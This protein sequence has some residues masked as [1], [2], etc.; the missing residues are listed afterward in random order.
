MNIAILVNYTAN[1]NQGEKKWLSI[2][3]DILQMLPVTT[4]VITYKPPFNIEE[5]VLKLV[6]EQQI[7]YIIS[8]GGDGS[9]NYILNSIINIFGELTKKIHL[10]A[11]GLGSS[12]DFLK[13]FSKSIKGIPVKINLQNSKMIDIGKVSFVNSDFN[14]I[15][16]YFIINASIG[17]TADANLLFNRGDFFLNSIKSRFVN[18]AI[19]YAAIKTIIRY[20]NKPIRLYYDDKMKNIRITNIS[21]VKNPNISGSFKYDQKIEPDDGM[22]GLNYCYNM[23]L[24][25]LLQ[26]LID[27]QKGKFSVK[28]KRIS[29]FVKNIKIE[30]DN[31]IA[32][33][34]DGEVVYA[35]NIKFSIIPKAIKVLEN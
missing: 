24:F 8:A 1:N 34:T 23:N 13:P 11:I 28:P 14:K 2:K 7:N 9:I 5:C 27:L 33:E 19:S 25:E 17:V 21:V 16:S 6:T 10:G 22:L 31:F 26:V 4:K 35:K 30:S 32:L 3:K 12:N 20:K 29:L 18:L 15:T